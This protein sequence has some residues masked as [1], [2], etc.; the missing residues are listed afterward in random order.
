L[1]SNFAY[2]KTISNI[3]E[4]GKV[5]RIGILPEQIHV[6]KLTNRDSNGDLRKIDNLIDEV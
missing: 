2:C 3:T 5:Y 4:E 1:A 6:R